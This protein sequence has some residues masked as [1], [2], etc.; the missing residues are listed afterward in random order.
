MVAQVP[1]VSPAGMDFADLA[2]FMTQQGVTQ[3]LNLDGGSSATLVYE[4]TAYYGRL[5]PQGELIQRP[6]KSIL[7]I[8]QGS[9]E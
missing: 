6:V 5:N 1:G 3:A 9:L 2:E 8:D 7:W 4:R